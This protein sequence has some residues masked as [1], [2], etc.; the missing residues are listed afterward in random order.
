MHEAS[1]DNPRRSD[2]TTP[3]PLRRRRP[4]RPVEVV[5]VRRLGD[6]FVS[7]SFAG[8]LDGFEDSTPARHLKVLIP[9]AGEHSVLVPEPGPDGQAWPLDQQRPVSR[10]YTPRRYDSAAGLLEV[11]FLLHGDGPAAAWAARAAVGDRLGVAG[12]GGRPLPAGPAGARWVIGGDESAVPAIG[13]LLEA[14]PAGTV[15][16]VY[17]EGEKTGEEELGLDGWP[18]VSWLPADD[19]AP[20]AALC[21]VLSNLSLPAGTCVWVAGEASAVRQIRRARIELALRDR[22]QV[23]PACLVTRGYWKAGAANHPDHDYGEDD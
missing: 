1:S 14:L 23:D 15:E 2:L 9:A 13:T 18:P 4:F 21:D 6:R 8:A 3:A 17:I 20:G 5:G 16:A 19:A 7:V 11:Q 10:T 22:G 12:P